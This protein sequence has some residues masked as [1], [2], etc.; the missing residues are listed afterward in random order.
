[1]NEVPWLSL[2]RDMIGVKEISGDKHEPKILAMWRD[3][4]LSFSN[5]EV[6]W[7]AALVGACLERCY[8]NSTRKANARSYMHWGNDVLA[9]GALQIP[10]GSIV[11]YSRPPND[12]EGHVGFAVGRTESG[13]IMTLGGNQGNAV[14]IKPFR[15][16]RLIAARWPAEFAGDLRMLHHIPLMQSTGAISTN[17]A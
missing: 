5:D 10:L 6:A 11:V 3:S 15:Y 8:V 9:N 1:M 2:A 13:D 4:H 16:N 7:C 12:W 17:E 14:N